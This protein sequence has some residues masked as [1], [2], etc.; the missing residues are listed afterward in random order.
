LWRHPNIG[1]SSPAGPAALA[2]LAALADPRAELRAL[3]RASAPGA[4]VSVSAPIGDATRTVFAR[5]EWHC[6]S[7]VGILRLFSRCGFGV[8]AWRR[9]DH[10][11]RR[12]LEADIERLADGDGAGVAARYLS[13]LVA[14]RR[15][16]AERLVVVEGPAALWGIGSD[17][18]A[19]ASALPA[20]REKL[21]G[22]RF[23]FFDQ[24]RVGQECHGRIVDSPASLDIF[25]GTVYPTPS[26]VSVRCSM[27]VAALGWERARFV[28]PYAVTDSEI[29]A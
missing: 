8:R 27:R 6:F 17:L 24:A 16:A 29:G 3:W 11:G 20:L 23:A 25:A 5:D 9:V 2:N 1:D 4:T 26:S 13:G 22:G 28:D 14:A 12:R 10:D 18:T 7:E 19:M 15:R 21:E